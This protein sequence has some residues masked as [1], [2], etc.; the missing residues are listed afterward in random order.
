MG[1]L[2]RLLPSENRFNTK[3]SHSK[4]AKRFFLTAELM[5]SNTPGPNKKK[6]ELTVERAH[7]L[8]S[9]KSKTPKKDPSKKE[10]KQ[11]QKKEKHRSKKRDRSSTQA[12][13]PQSTLDFRCL[14]A[15]DAE[16]KA[17]TALGWDA[18]GSRLVTG[19]GGGTVLLWDT[20]RLQAS[21]GSGV[22]GEA[23]PLSLKPFRSL[24]PVADAHRIKHVAWSGNNLSFLTAFSQF[25]RV[26]DREGRQLAQA[27]KGYPFMTD[28]SQTKGHVAEV[29]GA[30]WLGL[31]QVASA[32]MDSTIRTW[33]LT[34]SELMQ[35][36]VIK[37]KKQDGHRCP[38]TCLTVPGGG[39]SSNLW[40]GGLDGSLQSFD[41][42]TPRPPCQLIPAAHEAENVISCVTLAADGH[43]L[44]S[45]SCD[46]SLRV[47]DV[48]N[49]ERGPLKV[50]GSLPSYSAQNDCVFTADDRWL[51]TGTSAPDAG[52]TGNLV[53]VE[54]ASL[55][56]VKTIRVSSH[57]IIKMAYHHH[58][59]Q[60]YS[61]LLATSGAEL[62]FLPQDIMNA[63]IVSSSTD[64]L[65]PCISS[66]PSSEPS[67]EPSSSDPIVD[68]YSS[69][70]SSTSSSSFD[71][72]HGSKK[73]RCE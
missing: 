27:A 59:K 6:K 45:R 10:K 1:K 41:P 50:F 11:K 18:S 55:D 25:I 17:F 32:S 36:A 49:T 68:L 35:C 56:L 29:S 52:S 54:K 69:S 33:R 48:R 40:V 70:T 34:G 28:L 51:V 38:L 64:V 63:S 66:D 31:D 14:A 39:A 57:S 2:Q 65:S 72:S 4:K 67:S 43:T 44:A 61:L 62:F 20:S 8:L 12:P 19:D 37:A 3:N 60:N 46:G 13:A 73:L 26:C 5:S 47:F 71:L 21:A 16:W 58:P 23:S 53:V 15:R 24:E 9:G 42:R 22:A 30:G 7:L